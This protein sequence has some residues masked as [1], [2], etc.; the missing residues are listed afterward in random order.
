MKFATSSATPRVRPSFSSGSTNARPCPV[1]INRAAPDSAI[2]SLSAGEPSPRTRGYS[3][4]SG[5]LQTPGRRHA[6]SGVTVQES[7]CPLQSRRHGRATRA[8]LGPAPSSSKPCPSPCP[9][10]AVHEQEQNGAPGLAT[11][12]NRRERLRRTIPGRFL[13]RASQVRI[14]PRAPGSQVKPPAGTCGASSGGGPVRGWS[15]RSPPRRN[16]ASAD[17]T[18][19]FAGR[20]MGTTAEGRTDVTVS[21]PHRWCGGRL[22]RERDRR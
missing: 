4:R 18:C 13:N 20:R 14:L 10:T 19:S 8:P 2:C 1:L 16:T 7:V 12:T 3:V 5:C 11:C 15:A 17:S 9:S 21:A 6:R 22:R